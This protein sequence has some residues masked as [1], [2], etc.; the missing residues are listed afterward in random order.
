MVSRMRA[1]V[2]VIV[3]FLLLVNGTWL[4]A[5]Q[6]RLVVSVA[7][8]F[9][10]PYPDVPI[11]VAEQIPLR[12]ARDELRTRVVATAKT[13]ALGIAVITVA[14]SQREYRVRLKHEA[15]GSEPSSP[16]PT[17]DGIGR[18]WDR[19]IRAVPGDVVVPFELRSDLDIS[20]PVVGPSFSEAPPPRGVLSGRVVSTTGEAVGSVAVDVRSSHE[21]PQVRTNA[22]GSYRIAISP[23]RYTVNLS[24]APLPPDA[25]SRPAV[26]MYERAGE[27]IPVTVVSRYETH[28]AD[29]VVTPVYLFNTTVVVTDDLGNALPGATVFFRSRRQRSSYFNVSGESRV[30]SDGSV[31]LGPM[32]PGTVHITAWGKKGPL[33]LAA[34][35]SI[36][37]VDAPRELTMQLMPAARVTGRVEFVDRLAPLHGS[38]GLRVRFLGLDRVQRGIRSDDSDGLVSPDGDFSVMNVIGE[39]CLYVDGLPI[40][41]RLMDVTYER[42]NYTKRLFS[43]EQGREVL[44]VLVRIEPGERE[45]LS[46]ACSL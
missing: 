43:F 18:W 12:S 27:D 29:I 9:G 39:R 33:Q 22:D 44:G 21:Y 37:I 15:A 10:R 8:Q 24:A 40:G 2:T 38:S 4:S 7:D 23:G 46:P 5:Q 32:A 34:E 41:W 17:M 6:S 1:R 13:D 45:S 28:A 30:E 16:H 31:K 36:E 20:P 35:A 14:P 25:R 26:A 19:P 11:E 3:L 42:E